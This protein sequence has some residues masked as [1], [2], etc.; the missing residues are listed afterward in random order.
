MLFGGSELFKNLINSSSLFAFAVQTG[1]WCAWLGD[2]LTE[3]TLLPFV[4]DH[5]G[6]GV[7]LGDLL[8]TSLIRKKCINC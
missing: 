3:P 4:A 8:G 1:L 2:D 5:V 6:G 7:T